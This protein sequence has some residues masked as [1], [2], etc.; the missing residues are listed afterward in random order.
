LDML[1]SAL[2]SAGCRR[3][4]SLGE[5]ISAVAEGKLGATAVLGAGNVLT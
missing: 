2:G 1:Q 5:G 3:G 4:E